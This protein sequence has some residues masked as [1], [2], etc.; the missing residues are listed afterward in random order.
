MCTDQYFPCLSDAP[1]TVTVTLNP[2]G[3]VALL[4][5]TTLTCQAD[6]HPAPGFSWKFN[7]KVVDGARQSTLTLTRLEV[8]DAGNYTCVARNDWGSNENT[9]VVNVK[10][11]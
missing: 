7:G 1:Q 9:G 6:G 3:D 2:P 8:K 10:C 4:D 5:S 11:K